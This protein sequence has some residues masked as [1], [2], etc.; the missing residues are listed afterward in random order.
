MQ[1]LNLTPTPSR[2]RELRQNYLAFPETIAQSIANISPTLT[3]VLSIP[4]VVASAGNGTWLAYLIATLGLLLVGLNV[5]SF[6]QRHASAGALYDYIF[7]G[8]GQSPGFLGGWAMLA[9]YLSTAMALLVGFAIFAVQ[10]LNQFHIRIPYLPVEVVGLLIAATLAYKDIRVSSITALIMEFSSVLLISIL[11]IILLVRHKTL[12]DSAQLSL[13]HVHPSGI[14]L[15]LVLGVFSFVG[16]ESSTTLGQEAKNPHRSIPA[17]VIISVLIA[18]VFFTSMAY[19][20]V[21]AFPG[22]ITSLSQSTAPL[23]AMAITYHLSGFSLLI[24]L[25]AMISLFSC[26]LAS[27]NAGARILFAMGRNQ[28]IHD[29]VGQ[30]HT[31]NR[32]PHIAVVIASGVTL[33]ALIAL[34]G[35]KPLNAY[36]YFGTYATYGFLVAYMLVSIASPVLDRRQNRPWVGSLLRST[37]AVIFLLIP[38]IGSVYPVP[39]YPYN[40]LPYLF[41][42]YLGIGFIWNRLV[43]S[44][45]PSLHLISQTS[46]KE[47]EPT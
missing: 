38:I 44:G 7:E 32:T 16:F 24:D 11:S 39:A 8:L 2:H 9:A 14:A 47:I 37:G 33:V 4:L 19:F 1:S 27:L 26:A 23:N 3:P 43:A 31:V 15:G 30:T 42:G 41:L 6:A 17:A 22:G 5:A 10:I 29:W 13:A 21:L 28:H 34:A 40:I 20:E 35:S 12:W 46:P 18:G 25:G 45:K 36:G